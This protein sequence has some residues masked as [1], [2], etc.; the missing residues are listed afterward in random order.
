VIR[1]EVDHI[2]VAFFKSFVSMAELQKKTKYTAYV[3]N[4][5]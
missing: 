5:V 1:I 3:K 2:P 4:T